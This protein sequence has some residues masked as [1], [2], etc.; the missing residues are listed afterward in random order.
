ML[1]ILKTEVDSDDLITCWKRNLCSPIK[2]KKK[3]L[4]KK[5]K[6]PGEKM[7][8]RRVL[9]L[10]ANPKP[11]APGAS[12]QVGP[13]SCTLDGTGIGPCDNHMPD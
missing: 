5:K 10:T 1:E 2:E 8:C 4:K 3:N 6:I 13:F 9:W 11:D 7:G 12:F